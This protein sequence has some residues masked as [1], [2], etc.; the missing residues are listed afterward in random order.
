MLKRTRT[1]KYV[2]NPTWL[3]T[4][5][6]NYKNQFEND[7]V[8]SWQPFKNSL[9]LHTD[10]LNEEEMTMFNELCSN[11][12]SEKIST[13]NYNH[14]IGVSWR[15]INK[16][17]ACQNATDM[18]AINPSYWE[19]LTSDGEWVYNLDG[20][21]NSYSLF[22]GGYP[23]TWTCKAKK[24]NV[25]FNSLTD[26]KTWTFA[27]M[28][29][30]TEAYVD[31]PNATNIG[32]CFA[33]S[34][35]LRYIKL[36]APKTKT[37]NSILWGGQVNAEL[38][39]VFPNLSNCNRFAGYGSYLNVNSAKRI[40]RSLPTWTSG[41]H[42]LK[43]FLIHIDGETDEELI[44]LI[45]ETEQKGWTLTITWQGTPTTQTSSTYSSRKHKTV[46]AKLSEIENENGELVI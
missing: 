18:K 35:K 28:P 45:A 6:R 41:T 32:Q 17:N 16:Y 19:D 40:L 3:S 24:V 39:A 10:R 42:N 26:L 11:I 22:F 7:Y 9:I 36:N 38:D 1:K 14:N 29:N 46:Y 5:K 44:N 37:I 12:I 25:H 21:T 2:A 27:A 31:C 8:F 13:Q 23:V 30:L 20:I 33:D 4:L 34:S 43:D 15:Y